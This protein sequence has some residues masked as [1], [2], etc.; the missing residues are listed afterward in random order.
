MIGQVLALL[1]VHFS[2]TTQTASA[3][4]FCFFLSTKS[5]VRRRPVPEN[6]RKIFGPFLG[7]IELILQ[8]DETIH[9]PCGHLHYPTTQIKK[10]GENH[11]CR[12]FENKEIEQD[13]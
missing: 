6:K 5:V 7:V 1:V 3:I 10:N 12:G 13:L 11:Q 8:A 9:D 2:E 4:R